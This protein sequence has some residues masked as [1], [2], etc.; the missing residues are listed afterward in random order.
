MKVSRAQMASW[1]ANFYHGALLEILGIHFYELKFWCFAI[2]FAVAT[3]FLT[4][5]V[6]DERN[7]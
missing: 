2:P 4:N 5:W 1:M 3:T 6:K 7:K